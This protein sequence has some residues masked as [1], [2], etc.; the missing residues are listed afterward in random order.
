MIDIQLVKKGLER[1]ALVCRE[2]Q[3]HLRFLR[4]RLPQVG[5]GVVHTV[6]AALVFNLG[7]SRS[8]GTAAEESVDV[9]LVALSLFFAGSLL[10]STSLYVR[11]SS[12]SPIN[13]GGLIPTWKSFR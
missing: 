2:L 4:F 12:L 6:D 7:L 3:I 5:L 11:V 9:T 10:L 1:G 13:V 8:G